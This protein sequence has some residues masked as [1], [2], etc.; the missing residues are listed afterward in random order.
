MSRSAEGGEDT[1]EII[2]YLLSDACKSNPKVRVKHLIFRL[3]IEHIRKRAAFR[4][5]TFQNS[6]KH[7]IN[8][9][10]LFY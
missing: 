1:I 6:V 2:A 8:S 10:Y 5:S 7:D 3:E 9:Y 4:S